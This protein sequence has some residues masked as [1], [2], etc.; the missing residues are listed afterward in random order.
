MSEP[1]KHVSL[2][3][4]DYLAI[5]DLIT[6]FHD[7]TSFRDLDS[8]FKSHLLPLFE[9]QAGLYGSTDPEINSPRLMETYG[10]NEQQTKIFETYIPYDPV[11]KFMVQ[12]NR[13]VGAH[14]IDIPGA[15]GIK[16]ADLFAK[17]HPE[18]KQADYEYLLPPN[19]TAIVTL[20][21][22]DPSLGI[23][24]H[25]RVP[26]NKPFSPKDIR[27][28]E[29]IRPHLLNT[30]KT[31]LLNAELIKYKSIAEEVL[32]DS[33]TAMALVRLDSEVTFLNPAFQKLFPIKSGHPLPKGLWEVIQKELIKFDPPFD[34][35]NTKIELPFYKLS[36]QVYRLNITLIKGQGLDEDKCVL[37]RVKPA[38]EPYSKMNVFM[39]EKG[40]TGRE[41]EVCMLVRNGFDNKDISARLFISPNTV[42]NHL[43][44]IHRKL[45]VQ[46]RTQLIALLNTEQ[47][48]HS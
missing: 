4:E 40:L 11:A 12:H 31:I 29:L 41:M 39:Q 7:C 42:K 35:D 2:P 25:R 47:D 21:L 17:D 18:W 16:A 32:A 43:R 15:A 10:F 45:D 24:I 38:I 9:A 19:M 22:P 23:A 30:I 28:M 48:M 1:G 44:N 26:Y 36:Q 20:D 6:R 46:T 34:I 3:E 13:P 5:L 27:M 37:L 33:L 8:V 14:E